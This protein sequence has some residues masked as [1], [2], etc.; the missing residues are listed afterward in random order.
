MKCDLVSQK[1]GFCH[2]RAAWSFNIPHGAKYHGEKESARFLMCNECKE[3]YEEQ[4]SWMESD[5]GSVAICPGCHHEL[6]IEEWIVN[7]LPL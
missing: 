3:E 4:K 6:T 5:D 7:I 1:R 2:N